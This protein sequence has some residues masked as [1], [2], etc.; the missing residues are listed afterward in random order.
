ML[1]QVGGVLAIV[2][3]VVFGL[4]SFQIMENLD[5]N[6]VMVIQDPVDGDLHV[7]TEP[8]VYSQWFG[9]VTKYPRRKQYSFE[10]DGENE[11]TSKRLRFNDGGHANLSGSVSWEMPLD[12][13]SIKNIQKTFGSADGVETQAVA[14]MIDSA[15]YMSGPLMSS[16]ESSGERRAELV[17]YINDQATLGVYVTKVKQV[18]TKDPISGQD[19]TISQT[20]IQL[21]DKGTPRR[22]QGSILNEFNI[23]LMPISIKEIAYD[24]VVENQIKTRQESITQVQIAQANAKKAEQDA[25]T[26]EKQGEANAAK[27]KWD[28]EVIKAKEVTLA[29]QKLEVATLAAKEAEQF[30][31]EQIL[32][33]EG[34]AERKRLVMNA[35]GALDPKLEAY[36]EVNKYWADAIAKYQGN[37]VP[38][39]QMGGEGGKGNNGAA[40]LMNML[41][42]KTAKDLALDMSIPKGNNK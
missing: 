13:E 39:V 28:Q 34:E 17:Q 18:T 4:S 29:Q 10:Q 30:K 14:K 32:R 33:G 7:F 25:I 19:R 26:T 1:K 41:S 12:E 6:E 40:D 42:A 22:Q 38:T 2:F 27:A 24:A 15:I 8:G 9:K 20:D 31:R 11:G 23:K 35:D 37:W 5:A 36:K 3:L 21:D 16:T